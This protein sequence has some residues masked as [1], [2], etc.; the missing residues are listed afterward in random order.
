MKW[1]DR[2]RN[3]IHTRFTIIIY[4]RCR[5]RSAKKREIDRRQTDDRQREKEWNRNREKKVTE[6]TMTT[7]DCVFLL[8]ECVC[9]RHRDVFYIGLRLNSEMDYSPFIALSLSHSH[10]SLLLS[11]AWSRKKNEIYRIKIWVRAR[12]SHGN[13]DEIL[14]LIRRFIQWM[15]NV[16]FV[17][18]FFGIH[19]EK[20]QQKLSEQ[21]P[22]NSC[23]STT[24]Y[25]MCSN[26]KTKNLIHLCKVKTTKKKY[27]KALLDIGIRHLLL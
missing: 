2:A 10:R 26:N 17:S 15:C 4:K 19:G 14:L 8:C 16:S 13:Y 7:C 1:S 23:A 20:Q 6:M 24:I 21:L 25:Y 3:F 22:I 9:V 12:I 27:H 5:L 11:N 18:V